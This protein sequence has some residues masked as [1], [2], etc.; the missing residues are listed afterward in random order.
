MYGTIPGRVVGKFNV[1]SKIKTGNMQKIAKSLITVAGLGLLITPMVFWPQAQ[2]LSVLAT[3]AYLVVLGLLA[4]LGLAIIWSTSGI[5]YNKNW[6]S[7]SLFAFVVLFL[8]TSAGAGTLWNPI[9]SYALLTRGTGAEVLM[10]S[11]LVLIVISVGA[12]SGRKLVGGLFVLSSLI[13]V[14]AL[15]ALGRVSIFPLL[16]LGEEPLV[17]SINRAGLFAGVALITGLAVWSQKTK[18]FKDL[19]NLLERNIIRIGTAAALLLIATIG[20]RFIVIP[21]LLGVAFLTAV[22]IK[23]DKAFSKLLVVVVLLV[24]LVL[25]IGGANWRLKWSP[26][27]SEPDLTQQAS[28][29]IIKE[30]GQDQGLK[31]WLAGSGWGSFSFLYKKHK[32]SSLSMSS[33]WRK[34]FANGANELWTLTAEKGLLGLLGWLALLAGTLVTITKTALEKI[35]DYW[36]PLAAVTFYWLMIFFLYP[37]SLGMWAVFLVSLAGTGALVRNKQ[38]VNFTLAARVLCS[39]LLLVLAGY[40]A[41]YPLKKAVA[42]YYVNRAKQTSTYEQQTHYYQIAQ[43]ILPAHPRVLMKQAQSTFESIQ[44]AES[45]VSNDDL[46]RR[47]ERSLALG[48]QAVNSEFRDIQLKFMVAKLYADAAQIVSEPEPL[49]KSALDYIDVVRNQ[50]P[51]SPRPSYQAAQTW[52]VMA[53][54]FENNDQQSKVEESTMQVK[55]NLNRTLDKDSEFAL[56]RQELIRLALFKDEYSKVVD[57]GEQFLEQYPQHN[58]VR[59]WVAQSYY[60]LGKVEQARAHA[61]KILEQDHTSIPALIMAGKTASQVKDFEKAINYFERV[62]SQKPKLENLDSIIT[63]L[64]Q[65]KNPFAG[66]E[67]SATSTAATSTEVLNATATSASNHE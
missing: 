55:R 58:A 22:R 31:T 53:Q 27:P 61:E 20:A 56:A 38:S 28:W 47:L 16:F 19:S 21:A 64:H 30:A 35:P 60:D 41:Y 23:Q 5:S 54:Y 24:L 67:S 49:F 1:V 39:I 9:K 57:K 59:Q 8:A 32:P 13:A 33:W 63:D 51:D 52:F 48:E 37:F 43:K 62:R 12:R 18:L 25:A 3:Q 42:G 66:D 50:M 65:R 34:D 6:I 14:G 7:L 17:M 4:A 2:S 45:E 10:T 15:L 44:Q 11:L 36:L 29:Q 26:V 40:L 46:S